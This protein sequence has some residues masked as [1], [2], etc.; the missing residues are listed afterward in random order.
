MSEVA[1]SRRFVFFGRREGGES[2]RAERAQRR[3][4]YPTLFFIFL[5]LREKN[6]HAVAPAHPG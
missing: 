5:I 2:L 6:I 3:V 1:S 4:K